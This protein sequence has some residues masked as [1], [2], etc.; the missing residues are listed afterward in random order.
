M[1]IVIVIF[2]IA[3][4]F[5]IL[6]ILWFQFS[7]D[8]IYKPTF[9]KIEKEVMDPTLIRLFG[10]IYA[11]LLLAIGL[12]FFVLKNAR[13]QKEVILKGMLYG[14]IIYGVYNG[15]NFFTFN[16]Y[17]MKMFIADNFWGMIVSGIVSYISF[18][19]IN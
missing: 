3:L 9:Q 2:I 17:D 14:F 8:T 1:N 4:C 16:N 18:N 11:W 5:I 13:S 19:L 7:I 6:D 15:T 12:Y 10:G